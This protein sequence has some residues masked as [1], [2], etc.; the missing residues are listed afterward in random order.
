M[1]SIP[2]AL[3]RCSLALSLGLVAFGANAF[4]LRGFRGVA[5][6]QGAEALGEA[7]VAHADGDLA[8]YQRESESMLF[9]DSALNDVRYCFQ[10]NR[11]VMVA[12]DA[13]VDPKALALQFQRTYGRPDARKG[14]VASWGRRS[15]GARA[16]LVAQ[17][18]S[19]ARLTL[20]ANPIEPAVVQRLHKLA[21]SDPAPRVVASAD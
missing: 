8:C 9:G 20:Y 17:G 21:S 11:L 3:S 14:Q 5:W 15:T 2:A 4:E 7:V 10:H 6:G 1:K 19:A 12:L 16:E 18:A 13:A